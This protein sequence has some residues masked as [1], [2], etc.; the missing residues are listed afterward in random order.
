MKKW[1]EWLMYLTVSSLIGVLSLEVSAAPSPAVVGASSAPIAYSDFRR[2]DVQKFIAELAEEEGFDPIALTKIFSEAK[3][4]Q[5]I[6]DAISRPA[7]R[8]L[9]WREY[10]DIF[11]TERRVREGKAFMVEYEATLARAYREHGVPPEIVAAIIGVETMYGSI[12]GNYRVID[13]LSTLA[14][15]YP[16]RGKFFRS[17]LKQFFL[18]AR[19]EEQNPLELKGSYAGAMGFG[20]FISSSYRAYAVDFDGDGV[21]DIWHNPIDAIGSVA[22]Y[23]SRH[24]WRRGDGVTQKV[25]VQSP[26]DSLDELFNVNL[27]VSSDVARLTE[28]GVLLSE[29]LAPTTLVSPMRLLGKHG[30]EYWLGLQNFYVITRYNHSKLYAMA[31]FQLSERLK[32][33]G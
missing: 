25:K 8:T 31:V 33:K 7:E 16:P 32:V 24:G 15:D 1:I 12:T 23:L 22:N 20:Q 30:Y 29:T 19:E 9:N 17:E 21:R 28:L 18:L 4:K 5:K 3:F 13:S 27:A 11:L 26:E 10:Q 14:F 6:I 2:E